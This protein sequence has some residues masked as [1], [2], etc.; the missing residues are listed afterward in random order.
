MNSEEHSLLVLIAE[1][2]ENAFKALFKNHR[3]KIFNYIFR[4]TKSRVAAEEM[5]MDVFL[6]LWEGRALLAELDNFNAFLFAMARNKAYDFLRKAAKDRVLREL[7]WEE[8][9]IASELRTDQK[10]I[11]DEMERDY[12][13]A[14]QKLSPQRQ[15]VFKLSRE[16][17]MTY[18]QIAEHLQL[19][20]ST[21]KNHILDSL[22]AIRSHMHQHNNLLPFVLIVELFFQSH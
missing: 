7:I 4:L 1:G 2:N 3:A 21:I 19:S 17:H 18:D 8:I 9:Q 13:Y 22:K 12:Q 20:K 15:S 14:I 10:L 6:K 11:L 5:V 16:E